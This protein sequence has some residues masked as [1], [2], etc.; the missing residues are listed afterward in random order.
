M[1]SKAL[2]LLL[3]LSGST[4]CGGDVKDSSEDTTKDGKTAS[5]SANS[6]TTEADAGS[7]D[8][9]KLGS[10]KKG[11]DPLEQPDQ[12]CNWLG[13]DGLCYDDRQ[14]AC[15]CVCPKDCSSLCLSGFYDGEGSR[16]DVYCSCES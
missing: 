9:Q 11:F 4:G 14:A 3:A 5:P 2:F 12:P 15:N 16:T 6:S 7:S 10:C 13:D 8:T 1:T